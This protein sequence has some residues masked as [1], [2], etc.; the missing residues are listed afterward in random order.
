[1]YGA[2][3]NSQNLVLCAT[4]LR[5]SRSRVFIRQLMKAG[6]DEFGDKEKSFVQ[7]PLSDRELV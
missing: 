4:G 6:G 3:T 7:Y 2:A 5:A 1:M